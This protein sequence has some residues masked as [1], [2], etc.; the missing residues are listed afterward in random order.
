V[1][2]VVCAAESATEVSIGCLSVSVESLVFDES[3]VIVESAVSDTN[4]CKEYQ[5]YPS[6]ARGGEYC[7]FKHLAVSPCPRKPNLEDEHTSLRSER[8]GTP[9]CAI[10]SVPANDSARDGGGY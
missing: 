7:R 3:P 2:G 10:C 4:G 5:E 6:E 1:A 8:S 9:D